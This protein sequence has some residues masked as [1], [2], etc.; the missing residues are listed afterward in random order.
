[1]VKGGVVGTKKRFIVLRKS[2]LR[3]TGRDANENIKL[4]FIDTSSKWGHGRF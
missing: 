3:N 4:K 1:M 2:L